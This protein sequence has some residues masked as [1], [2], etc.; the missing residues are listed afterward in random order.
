M[1]NRFYIESGALGIGPLQCLDA[2]DD[3]MVTD[4]TLHFV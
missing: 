4:N 3:A 2:H 1:G